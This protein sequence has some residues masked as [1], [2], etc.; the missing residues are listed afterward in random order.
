MNESQQ[1]RF[2]SEHQFMLTCP[3]G[4]LPAKSGSLPGSRPNFHLFYESQSPPGISPGNLSN[5]PKSRYSLS[6]TNIRP[7]TDNRNMFKAIACEDIHQSRAHQN[8]GLIQLTMLFE[9]REQS[10]SFHSLSNPEAPAQESLQADL[11]FSSL[12]SP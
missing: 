6:I 3:T 5:F 2:S 8:R 11:R 4:R 12:E 10:F 9:C 7:H 1:K